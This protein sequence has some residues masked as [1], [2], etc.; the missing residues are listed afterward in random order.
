VITAQRDAVSIGNTFATSA[1]AYIDNQGTL[2][3]NIGVAVGGAD[4]GNNT[5]VNAGAIIGT[6]GTAVQ[7]GAGNNLLIDDPGAGFSGIVQGGAGSNTLELA[8]GSATGILT[9]LGTSFVDFA[10]V[11]VDPA[12]VW[13]VSDAAGAAPAFV[14]DG[15]VLVTGGNMLEFGAVGEDA[16][17]SGVIGVGSSGVAE[18]QSTVAAGQTLSFL[19]ATGTAKLDEPAQFGATIAG[20]P[21]GDT[22]DLV[23]TPATSLVYSGGTLT[24]MNSSAVVAALTIA[25]S[26]VPSQFVLSSDDHGGN[27]I[28]L[29]PPPPTNIFDF[30]FTYN[31]GKD[32]Y[33]GTVADNGTSGYH[34]GETVT[35][36]SGQYDIFAQ[37]GAA[38]EAAGTVFVT[39]YSRG[40]PGQA[41]YLPLKTG[42]GQADGSN[43]LGSES[44]SLL[45][46][47]GLQHPFSASMGASFATSGLYGF[48]FNYSNGAAYY[49]GTVADAGSLG[50]AEIANSA[51]PYIPVSDGYYYIFSEGETGEASGT[52]II[53][54]YRDGGNATTYSTVDNG[55]AGLGSESGFFLVD[56]TRFDFSPTRR[57]PIQRCPPARP[58]T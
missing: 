25:G 22:I 7:F 21:V 15:T 28:T 4:I 48:V 27:Q 20:F 16:G 34:S 52:V 30:V 39:Y 41:S 1:A 37:A 57:P 32:H 2:T 26:Y 3:G 42:L 35:T 11:R 47:D 58:P 23:D 6:S 45:G 10:T 55:S 12:A 50:Y 56:G 17:S 36:A 38:S 40:G 51:S 18:F 5:L 53:N 43:G 33:D 13:Q 9:G 29:T 49:F 14:N 44:D 19:D 31:D 54:G 8:A 46:T 24:V